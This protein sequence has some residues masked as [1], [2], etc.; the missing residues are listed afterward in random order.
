M[1]FVDTLLKTG[2]N[3]MANVGGNI[4]EG[5]SDLGLDVQPKTAEQIYNDVVN[6][7]G[8]Q[9]QLADIN[10]DFMHSQDLRLADAQSDAESQLYS[11]YAQMGINPYDD[12]LFNKQLESVY[13][14]DKAPKNTRAD[15]FMDDL[16]LD[17][18]ILNP[19]NW[20][21]IG[22]TDADKEK[23]KEQEEYKINNPVDENTFKPNSY[24][25][26]DDYKQRY[27][28]YFNDTLLCRW[29]GGRTRDGF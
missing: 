20:P 5:F 28:D 10:N 15:R 11:Q 9:Q 7:N 6:Y 23:S 16:L 2:S 14:I 3:V 12:P 24:E 19:N 13:D 21:I 29:L 22:A 1:S 27:Q 4:A 26:T 18:G 8:S 25:L 17:D